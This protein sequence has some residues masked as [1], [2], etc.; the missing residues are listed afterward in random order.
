MRLEPTQVHLCQL[1]RRHLSRAD[2]LGQVRHR[3]ERHLLDAPWPLETARP[4]V[5][6][7]R[8]LARATG[9]ENPLFTQGSTGSVV[10]L[11]ILLAAYTS[12]AADNLFRSPIKGQ[13][14]LKWF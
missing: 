8:G 14:I 13:E 9:L 3:P 4:R 12:Y 5:P 7:N 6:K 10:K 1:G 2:H 11:L